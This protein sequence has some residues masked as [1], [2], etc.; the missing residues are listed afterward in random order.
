VTEPALRVVPEPPPDEAH[1][2]AR[3]RSGDQDAYETLVR[4]HEQAAFRVAFAILRSA[5]DA[6][7]V[8]QEAF[9][10][11]YRALAR[12]RAG[13]PFRPWLLRIVGNEARNW[14]R[15]SGRR[16]FHERRATMLEPVRTSAA[17]D[18]ALFERDERS[19]VLAAVDA[20]P[21]GERVAIVARYFIGLTDAEAAAALGVARGTVKMRAWRGL[22]KLQ[23]DLGEKQ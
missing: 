11:A 17:A 8:A 21:E 4:N 15:A 14:L 1:L 10:K 19:R 3:A 22:R 5:P 7:D 13:A 16:T 2:V 12:F 23:A 20:L 6:E 9:V 18:D